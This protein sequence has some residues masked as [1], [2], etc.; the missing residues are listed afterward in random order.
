MARMARLG[1][2]AELKGT[3]S[4]Q[5][6][7]LVSGLN[8]IMADYNKEYTHGIMRGGGGGN[9][10]VELG[11]QVVGISTHK[12]PQVKKRKAEWVGVVMRDKSLLLMYQI[13]N[14]AVSIRS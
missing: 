9:V 14:D 10:G 12:P 8:A 11:G 4:P 2:S 3:L 6:Q 7:Q 1:R 5:E 13:I